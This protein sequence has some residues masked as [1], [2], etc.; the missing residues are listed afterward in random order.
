MESFTRAGLRFDVTD[1]GP[2]GAPAVVLLH[3]FPQA[4]DCWSAITPAL[5]G[6]GLRVLAPDQRGYSPGARPRGRRAYRMDELVA[7]VVALL[8]AAGVARAHVVGHDWGGSVAWALA[9]WHPDRVATLTSLSTPH[10]A[11]LLRSF[12]TSRQALHSWYMVAFQLPAAPEW[13]LA[14]ST[15][16]RRAQFVRTLTRAGLPADRAE[17]YA[18]RFA[19]PGALGAAINWYRAIPL[20]RPG[21]LARRVTVPTLYLWGQRDQYL[22]AAP[23]R[24]T[25]DW[26]AGPYR[27]VEL[28]GAGHWLPECN[29]DTVAGLLLDHVRG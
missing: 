15:P 28:P 11:A 20:L 5:V 3:G 12:V 24:R 4:A 22:V 19:A 8:D 2:E 21:A 27:L 23:A 25:A 16:G 6:A 10:P 13:L 9:I 17:I 26:V 7:D 1:T 18:D 29:A 14:P